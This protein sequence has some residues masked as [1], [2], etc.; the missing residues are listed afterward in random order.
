MIPYKNRHPRRHNRRKNGLFQTPMY[1]APDQDDHVQLRRQLTLRA[2]AGL[3]GLFALALTGAAAAVALVIV[4]ARS[5]V[6][7]AEA[8]A[9]Y[10]GIA[11]AAA[12][13]VEALHWLW[14]PQP[15]PGGIAV[16]DELAP[17]FRRHR[18]CLTA[19]VC[20]RSHPS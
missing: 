3:L 5:P 18:A 20:E 1:D 16:P 19:P 6:G 10:F 4:A 7:P 12:L 13:S 2:A 11:V 14:A 15:Q 9:L 8:A 17:R